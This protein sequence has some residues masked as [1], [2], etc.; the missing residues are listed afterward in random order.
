M[1]PFALPGGLKGCYRSPARRFGLP[2]GEEMQYAASAW[3][4][5]AWRASVA[6][7]VPLSEPSSEPAIQRGNH[8]AHKS[9]LHLSQHDVIFTL[10]PF[11][12]KLVSMQTCQNTQN[13]QALIRS[14]L[15]ELHS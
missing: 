9:T 4:R 14:I 11:G 13:T 1:I 8:V 3:W 5:T 7:T 6:G 10:F 2:L 15:T 12:S